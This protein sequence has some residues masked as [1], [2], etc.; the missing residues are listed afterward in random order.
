[1]WVAKSLCR[2]VT[3]CDPGPPILE[4]QDLE[5]G[6]L[7]NVKIEVKNKVEVAVDGAGG[8]DATDCADETKSSQ[9]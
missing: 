1:M 2:I 9:S 8:T 6:S 5:R 7:R 3:C 4:L